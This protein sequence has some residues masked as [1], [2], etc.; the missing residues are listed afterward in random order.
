MSPPGVS[1]AELKGTPIEA[2]TLRKSLATSSRIVHNNELRLQ[3]FFREASVCAQ[4]TGTT[5]PK[6]W[7]SRK[8]SSLSARAPA[9]NTHLRGYCDMHSN[10]MPCP[11]G[12]H[13]TNLQ[14]I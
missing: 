2:A 12:I 10:N 9:N 6:A 7:K 8:Y 14:F 5:V 1:G 3:T 4:A 11:K 13:M